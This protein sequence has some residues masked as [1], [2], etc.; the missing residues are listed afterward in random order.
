MHILG[1]GDELFGKTF[2]NFLIAE[3]KIYIKEH[4]IQSSLK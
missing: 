3:Y 1:T 2:G 4:K